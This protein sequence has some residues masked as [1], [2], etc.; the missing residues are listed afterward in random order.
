MIPKFK[1]TN[2]NTQLN[3]KKKVAKKIKNIDKILGGIDKFTILSVVVV[4]WL[5]Y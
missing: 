3:K 4:R 2:T 5:R 1:I